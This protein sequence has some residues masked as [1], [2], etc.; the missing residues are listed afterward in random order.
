MALL[1]PLD[2]KDQQPQ[3]QRGLVLDQPRPQGVSGFGALKRGLARGARGFGQLQE[4]LGIP[5]VVMPA[6][7]LG[8]QEQAAV[9]AME[10]TARQPLAP[11]IGNAALSA[12][13]EALPSLAALGP[14]GFATTGPRMAAALG[15]AG[16]GIAAPAQFQETPLSGK[17]L[18][19]ETAKGVA[20]GGTIGALGGAVM[21]L[22]RGENDLF[23][24]AQQISENLGM[25][26]VVTTSAPQRTIQQFIKKAEREDPVFLELLEQSGD[27]AP[28][29]IFQRQLERSLSRNGIENNLRTLE[30]NAWAPFDALVNPQMQINLGPAAA[31]A[32]ELLDQ[33]LLTGTVK[34]QA[35]RILARHN[36]GRPTTYRELRQMRQTIGDLY[37]TK[38]IVDTVP[39]RARDRLY[40][41]LTESMRT[42]FNQTGDIGT[43]AQAFRVGNQVSSQVAR[44]RQVLQEL[45]F[46]KGPRA[47]RNFLVNTK[48]IS[49]NDL[50]TVLGIAPDLREIRDLAS[51]IVAPNAK[52][53]RPIARGQ[54]IPAITQGLAV[55]AS[56]QPDPVLGSGAVGLDFLRQTFFNNENQGSAPARAVQNLDN[57]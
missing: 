48:K 29:R 41:G 49:N 28:V 26:D 53:V 1:I 11:G 13:G 35:R 56:T 33:D 23:R 50:E 19:Q 51:I 43:A 9:Q 24:R 20:V 12:V 10:R 57:L 18:A 34:A 16:G 7:G 5:S 47:V 54:T 22:M 52:V 4:S 46:D 25:D 31:A 44:G 17:E 2:E 8:Q 38:Q 55:G 32:R 21:R 27:T 6:L 14:A 42:V 37:N 45:R 39:T 30:R 3:P 36:S 40:R 15:A